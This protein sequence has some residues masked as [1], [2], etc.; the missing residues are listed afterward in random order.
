MHFN[1]FYCVVKVPVGNKN[2]KNDLIIFLDAAIECQKKLDS[3]SREK[4]M[5]YMVRHMSR[6][7]VEM[8]RYKL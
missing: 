4:V 1:I 8:S 6:F 3:E 7:L 5:S 2:M